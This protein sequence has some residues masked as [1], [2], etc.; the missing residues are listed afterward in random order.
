MDNTSRVSLEDS[1]YLIQ[2]ARETALAKGRQTQ[3]SRLSPVEEEMRGLVSL[4]KQPSTSTAPSAGILGQS[5][6][7]KMLEV[8]QTRNST[9]IQSVSSSTVADRNRVVTAMASAEMSDIDIARQ[10]GMTR[11]EVRLVLNVQQK[12]KSGETMK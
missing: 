9:Q 3:A 11:D 1:L 5:D 4:S 8:S 10:M 6:F 12:G 2:M 7:K